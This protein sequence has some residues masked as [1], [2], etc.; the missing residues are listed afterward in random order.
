ML[1]IVNKKINHEKRVVVI[2]DIH[3]DLKLLEKLL[4]RIEYNEQDVLVINGD[5]CEKGPNSLG[6]VRYIMNLSTKSHQVYVTQG[7]C[8]IL[9]NHIFNEN[10]SILGYMKKQKHSILNEMLE[11][12]DRCLNDFSSFKE[13]STFYRN[14]FAN[15][16]DWL[17]SLPTA[18]ETENYIIIHAGIE[19][20]E[21]WKETNINF[22]LSTPGFYEKGHQANKLV[23][24]GH[25]PVT[26]YTATSIS[27]HNPIIDMNKRIICLDGGNRVK[28]D[29]QINALI[30]EED[31]YRHTYTDHLK[32]IREIKQNYSAP[33]GFVG[34]VTYPN[35]HLKK[36]VQEEYFTLCENVNLGIHQWIKNEY[37]REQKDGIYCKDD[38]S[39]TLLSV[40]VGDS[41]AI[42]DNSCKA[43]VLVKKNGQ[44]GWI[45]KTCI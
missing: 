9:I 19:N 34:T 2:S 10:D 4:S 11:E 29:G 13:L 23:I 45:P 41:V 39:T 37:I 14:H 8:D 43:F 42:I 24:V 1:H 28:S 38:L 30:I 36:L 22:A 6:V 44:V 5:L 3:G 12:Q 18:I 17:L 15:E 35:Y 21:N 16:I 33:E 25:W 32:E 31:F 40:K 26:N 27:H 20:I 7:N